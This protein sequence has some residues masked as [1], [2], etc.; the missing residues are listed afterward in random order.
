MRLSSDDATF[1]YQETTSTPLHSCYFWVLQGTITAAEFYEHVDSR[2][3]FLPRF[4][5][6]LAIVPFNMAHPK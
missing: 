3:H 2:L 4:R 1:L 6:K 5:R